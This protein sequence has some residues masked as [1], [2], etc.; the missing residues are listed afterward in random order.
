MPDDIAYAL[1]VRKA[2]K[3][4]SVDTAAATVLHSFIRSPFLDVLKSFVLCVER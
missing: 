3:S 2:E 1:A 4:C